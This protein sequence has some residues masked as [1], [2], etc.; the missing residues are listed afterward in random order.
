[1][2][3]EQLET[4]VRWQGGLLAYFTL[5]ILLYGIWRGTQRQAGLTTGRT[6]S[7]LRSPWFYLASSMLFFGI[8]YFG[9]IPLPQTFSP[10]SRA[11]TLG[12][13]SLLYFPGMSFILWGRLAL[14]KNYFVSTAFSAQ[15]FA[16]HQL[17]TSGPFAIVRHP[18][19]TGLFLAA[20]GSLLIYPT[21]TTLLFACF[22]PLISVRARREEQALAIEF[23][24]QWHEY[25]LRVPAFFPRLIKRK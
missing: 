13:S 19:Y 22:A 16:S 11:W 14:G 9:W 2:T 12:L 4:I 24:E 20:L 5:G 7:W 25:C 10:I 6:G 15:L 23:G 1:M 17:I 3:L 21:Y 8:C 18:M